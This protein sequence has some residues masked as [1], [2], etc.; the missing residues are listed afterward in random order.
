M[1][2]Q[3][4]GEFELMVLLA[5]IRLGEAEAYAVSIGDDIERHTGRSVQPASVYVTLQRLE[6]KGFVSSRMGDPLPERGGRARRLIRVE[7]AG[8][9]AVRAARSAF[10]N[11]WK[12]LGPV[13]D[14]R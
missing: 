9:T 2:K 14:E 7:A 4:L 12:G 11:M 13:L 6:E 3:G 5:A 10:T 1:G 8:L